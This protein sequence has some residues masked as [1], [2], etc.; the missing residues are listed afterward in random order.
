MFFRVASPLARLA[1]LRVNPEF[2]NDFS[3][4]PARSPFVGR[5]SLSAL[6]VSTVLVIAYGPPDLR[7]EVVKLW[8]LY[9]NISTDKRFK[10]S[11]AVLG[12]AG[13]LLIFQRG[14]QCWP[15]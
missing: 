1:S 5:L 10:L 6:L 2:S 3:L 4:R 12:L 8:E 11:L 13:A 9:P 14:A 15:E 7:N